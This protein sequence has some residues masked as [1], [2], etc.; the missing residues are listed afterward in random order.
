MRKIRLFILKALLELFKNK[1]FLWCP[2]ED[3]KLEESLVFDVDTMI[4]KV[5]YFMEV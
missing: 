5:E 2:A 1:I 4:S 3:D